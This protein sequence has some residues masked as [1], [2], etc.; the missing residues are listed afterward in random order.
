M[1]SKLGAKSPLQTELTSK[2]S[3]CILRFTCG[4]IGTI[5]SG[6]LRVVELAME[7]SAPSEEQELRDIQR[8]SGSSNTEEVRST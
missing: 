8:S 1:T 2:V 4:S 6:R 7:G 5:G 3:F